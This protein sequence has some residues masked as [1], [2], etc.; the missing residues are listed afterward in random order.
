M[1]CNSSTTTRKRK[2]YSK[3]SCLTVG[4]KT[5]RYRLNRSIVS[6]HCSD[7]GASSTEYEN[8][9]ENETSLTPHTYPAAQESDSVHK[10]QRP[11]NGILSESI[12]QRNTPS[13]RTK[14]CQIKPSLKSSYVQA[15][16]TSK[17]KGVHTVDLKNIKSCATQTKNVMPQCTKKKSRGDILKERL[18]KECDFEI[19]A[20]KLHANE[21]TNKFIKCISAL[22]NGKLQFTNMSWKCFLDMGA[23]ISCPSTTNMEYD[24]EWLEFCQVLYHMF[25]AGVI[26]ALHG[27]GH[28][29][30]VTSARTNK[31]KYNP[32]H[33]EFNFPIPSIPTLKKLDIGFP[34]EIP[35]GFVEQSLVLA[36]R[37]AEE[38]GQFVLSFDGKLIAPGCKGDS[39]GDSNLWGK[40]GPPNLRT[41]VKILHNCIFHHGQLN[42][43]DWQMSS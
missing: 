37:K 20:Q 3:R 34:S 38:G 5:K 22:A 4:K 9:S 16:V 33:G 41:A 36:Q 2:K 11:N 43:I 28:F 21:Q 7:S 32:V 13:T 26:N 6:I 23:L 35:V 8:N 42:Y 12:L 1:D 10:N 25:G 17:C 40:E 18:E 31:S 14:A 29:S 19:F 24:K 39:T 30:Q 27:R 15:C